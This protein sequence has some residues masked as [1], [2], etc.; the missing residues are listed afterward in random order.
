MSSIE[1]PSKEFRKIEAVHLRN[2]EKSIKNYQHLIKTRALLVDSTISKTM[3]LKKTCWKDLA[4][5]K[6]SHSIDGRDRLREKAT[7]SEEIISALKMEKKELKKCAEK[8]T[9]WM[10]FVRNSKN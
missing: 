10:N 8:C 6:R 1:S 4:I 3:N 9:G 7:K 5:A 2:V